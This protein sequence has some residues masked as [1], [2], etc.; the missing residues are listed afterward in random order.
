[1]SS[2]IETLTHLQSPYVEYSKWG[3]VPS[4][5]KSKNQLRE[6]HLIPNSEA[7]G[8]FENEEWDFDLYDM[9]QAEYHIPKTNND[10]PAVPLPLT[11]NNLMIALKVIRVSKE[12]HQRSFKYIKIH[13]NKEIELEELENKVIE[14][15]L[16]EGVEIFDNEIIEHVRVK[17][18]VA[19]LK[20][21][22]TSSAS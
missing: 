13:Q 3:D 4:N 5:L 6:M 17:D 7:E 10:I 21:Y 1:M 11:E 2:L 19:T 18:A 20:S 14:Q 16:S 22:L 9:I 8:H 15:F 12:K